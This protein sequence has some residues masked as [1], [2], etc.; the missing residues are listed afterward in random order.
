[1]ANSAIISDK[2]RLGL[3]LDLALEGVEY[4]DYYFGYIFQAT[5]GAVGF[6]DLCSFG[7]GLTVPAA[8]FG[9]AVSSTAGGDTMDVLVT[10]LDA[11][12]NLQTATKTLT[13]QTKA[14]IATLTW[15]WVYR[16]E[17]VGT[18][19]AAGTIWVF[20]DD[21]TVTAGVPDTQA[22]KKISAFVTLNLGSTCCF[23]V[24]TGKKAI[25]LKAKTGGPTFNVK[26]SGGLKIKRPGEVFK[27]CM[28]GQEGNVNS[29]STSPE[30]IYGNYEAGTEIRLVCSATATEAYTGELHLLLKDA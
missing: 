8:A 22:K 6:E 16:V 13:G 27:F 17:V 3:L 14:V 7:G 18:T 23:K 30:G 24:P 1:M 19:D 21:D 26:P 5:A 15:T 20:E 9:L 12:G 29:P 11:D 10:G 4:E 2:Q 28:L 25:I